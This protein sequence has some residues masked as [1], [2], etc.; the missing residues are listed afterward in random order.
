MTPSELRELCALSNGCRSPIYQCQNCPF[1][2]DGKMIPEMVA[3][4]FKA[5]P[6]HEVTMTLSHNEHKVYYRTVAQA[7]EDK[8][9][10]YDPEDFVSPEQM[11]KAIETN[12][13]WSLQWY[14]TTPVGFYHV[15]AC[16]LSALL[17][18]VQGK[19]WR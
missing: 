18:Y 12:E 13:C 15:S 19:D 7:I 14:P 5:L 8:D 2:K 17:E 10:G 4:F 16:E 9:H 3:E 6:P 1:R 11:K